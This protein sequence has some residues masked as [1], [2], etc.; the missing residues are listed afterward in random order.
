MNFTLAT[1]PQDSN[2]LADGGPE[3]RQGA[4]FKTQTLK[5]FRGSPQGF[6]FKTS[7]C[8]VKVRA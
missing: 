1:S 8:L 5:Y 2:A 3:N 6:H 4:N 7:S